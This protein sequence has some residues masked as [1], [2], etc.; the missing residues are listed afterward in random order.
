VFNLAARAVFG[1]AQL[2]VILAIVLFGPAWTLDYPEA[3]VYLAIFGGSA[4]LIAAYLLRK[5]PRLLERRLKAGPGAEQQ[6]TQNIIQAFAS[7]AFIGILVVPSLDRRLGWSHVPLP[8]V[9]LGDILVILG[10]FAVFMVFKVNSFTAGTIEVA[11]DQ[12]VIST[13]PY[14]IVRHP[15]YSGALVLLLGTPLALGS[16][17]GLLMV[18]PITLTIIWRLLDEERFLANNLQGYAAY[19]QTVRYRLLPFVW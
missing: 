8:I 12:Q 4:A 7:I 1:F 18:I 6:K 15:M 3:W 5:D 9:V 16:Y 17:W 2:L 19:C 13:G 14:A 11:S 10:F